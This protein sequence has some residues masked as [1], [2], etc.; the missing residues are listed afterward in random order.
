MISTNRSYTHTVRT[1]RTWGIVVCLLLMASQAMAQKLI[2][3]NLML[4]ISG[5]NQ[6]ET[7]LSPEKYQGTELRF[8]SQA[9]RETPLDASQLTK[10]GVK[11]IDTERWSRQITHD[12]HIGTAH[13]RADN[14]NFLSGFYHFTYTWL[15]RLVDTKVG[16]GVFQLKVGPAADGMI[17][18]VYSTRNGNNPAQLHLGANAAAALTAQYTFK[19]SDSRY[20]WQ[21]CLPVRI[22]YEA[23]LPVLGIQFSPNYGQSY[24]EIFSR[25]NYDHNVVCATPFNAPTLRQIVALDFNIGSGALRLGY[26]GEWKQSKFNDLKFHDWTNGFVIGYTKR[27]SITSHAL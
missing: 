3:R 1:H 25:G 23:L 24:Y 17:G 6:L 20:G 4:G 27:F 19:D 15:Y 2:E 8:V 14:A 9:T 21:R 16:K 26:I 5:I 22:S 18:G 13:N 10:A 11:D 7:Y 12:A